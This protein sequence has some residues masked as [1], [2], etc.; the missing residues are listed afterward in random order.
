MREGVRGWG[1]GDKKEGKR[2]NGEGIGKRGCKGEMGGRGRG[3]YVIGLWREDV[4]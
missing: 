2:L 1:W 4:L 3:K